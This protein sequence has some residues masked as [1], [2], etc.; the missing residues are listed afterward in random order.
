MDRGQVQLALKTAYYVNNCEY[1]REMRTLSAQ[2]RADRITLHNFRG[3][4]ITA[5]NALHLPPTH[6]HTHRRLTTLIRLGKQVT[7]NRVRQ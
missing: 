4:Q 7:S 5:S 3:I 2:S 6:T 1:R